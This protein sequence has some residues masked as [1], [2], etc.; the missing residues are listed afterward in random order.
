MITENQKAAILKSVGKHHISK[1]MTFA[2]VNNRK[3][4]DGG[5][6]SHSTFSRVLNGSLDHPEVERIIFDAADHYFKK[7]KEEEQRRDEFVNR[8]NPKL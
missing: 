1:I 7:T 2:T 5:E 8:V 3:K 4:E 6:Y